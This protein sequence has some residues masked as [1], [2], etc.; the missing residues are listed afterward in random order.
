MTVDLPELGE[1]E[2]SLILNCSR[3]SLNGELV[4]QTGKLLENYVNWDSVV[5]YS[6]YH[7]VAPLLY[8]NLSSNRLIGSVP[9]PVYRSLLSLKHRTEYQNKI[10]SGI[11]D[12]I[13]REFMIYDIPVI[14]LKGI[15]LVEIVYRNYG[16]RP[17]IDINLLIEENNLDKA[18]RLLFQN[19]YSVRNGDPAQGYGYSQVHFSKND[20]YEIHILLQWNIL[21][22]PRINGFNMDSIWENAQPARISKLDTLILSNEDLLMYLALQPDKYGY[23]NSVAIRKV[24]APDFIFR[25]WTN[26]R[27]IRYVDFYETLMLFKNDINWDSFEERSRDCTPDNTV[28]N[29]FCWTSQLLGDMNINYKE[30]K[31][32]HNLKPKFCRSII[33]DMLESGS[34]INCSGYGLAKR[35]YRWWHNQKRRTIVHVIQILNI[36]EYT[37]PNPIELKFYYG[38]GSDLY[39]LIYY[40]YHMTRSVILIL[41][42][43]FYRSFIKD[44]FLR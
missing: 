2:L 19:G 16:L 15:A 31:Q 21:N 18:S 33:Y 9:R 8:N 39:S 1:N 24:R 11:L 26:N 22:W 12:E 42:P 3:L 28:S 13:V 36:L 27:L 32:F 7:S 23:F 25:E 44:K 41:I 35:V 4:E 14:V 10:I 43:A 37:F 6:K 17:L 20:N 5:F 30:L 40:P 38:Y 34:L 29:C